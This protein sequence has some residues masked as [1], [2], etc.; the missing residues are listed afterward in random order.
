MQEGMQ[1]A[2]F[3]PLTASQITEIALGLLYYRGC[4][5]WRQNQIPVPGRKFIGKE[6]LSDIIGFNRFTGLM[7]MCEVKT[8]KDSLSEKQKCLLMDLKTAGGIA[9]L[10]LDD[11]KGGVIIQEYQP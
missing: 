1:Q 9:L 11:K 3:E 4:T 6:G 5:C 7:L 10:A 8:Q 2:K